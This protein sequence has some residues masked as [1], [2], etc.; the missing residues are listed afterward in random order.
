MTQKKLIQLIET[1]K[2]HPTVTASDEL[3]TLSLNIENAAQDIISLQNKN[4]RDIQNKTSTQDTAQLDS[5]SGCYVFNN[6]QGYFCP[7]CYDTRNERVPTQRLNR[8]LRVCPT[9]R[10]SIK[11]T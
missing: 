1:L 11:P 9:C 5:K 4:K 6:V 7:N 3:R 2:H 10:S 8:S